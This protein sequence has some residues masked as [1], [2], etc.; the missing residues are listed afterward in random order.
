[1]S[2]QSSKGISFWIWLLVGLIVAA[3]VMGLL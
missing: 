3:I 2:P 1:M